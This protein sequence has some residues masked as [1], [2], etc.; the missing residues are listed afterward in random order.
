VEAKVVSS[1]ATFDIVFSVIFEGAIFHGN[2][3]LILLF[4]TKRGTSDG[5][6][7]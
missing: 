6:L 4:L 2:P 1:S 5:K 3:V 7:K